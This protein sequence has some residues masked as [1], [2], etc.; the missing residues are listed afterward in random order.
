MVAGALVLAFVAYQL[1]GTSI[2]ESRAQSRLR[3]EFTD[4]LSAAGAVD[5]LDG[6]DLESIRSQDT[7]PDEPVS[8]N[9]DGPGSTTTTTVAA[10]PYGPPPPPVTSGDPVARIRIPRIDIDK[11]VVSGVSV[12]EL[13]AGPGHYPGTPLPGQPG[14][15]A[16]AGHRTTYGAPFYSLNELEDGDAIFVTT[17]QGSFE[18]RV[19][20]SEIVAPG[21]VHV[22]ESR[23][24]NELT[25]TTCNPRYSARERLVVWADLVG[26]PA[27]SDPVGT[28]GEEPPETSTPSTTGDSATTTVPAEQP[29]DPTET[30]GQ[31][32]PVELESLDGRDTSK[33]P[34]FG[35]GLLCVAIWVAG[36]VAGRQWK[37]WPAYAIA[38]PVF[39]VA[40]FMFFEA[41]AR[42]LPAAV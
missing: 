35:W 39:A 1:W 16:I 28:D 25:L 14:N 23:G 4:A 30:S 42:L 9:G 24:M 38:A 22:V 7:R 12:A 36:W 17:V 21:D 33:L 11:V 32:E 29:A 41:F 27:R 15:A 10:D 18:Y 19:S 31:P 3:G 26:P 20:G 6:V 2:H 5:P 13:K 37:R 40:L 34:A 8:Q